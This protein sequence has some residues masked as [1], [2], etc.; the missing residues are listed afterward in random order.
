MVEDT[1]K[2]ELNIPVITVAKAEGVKIILVLGRFGWLCCCVV[3]CGVRC[4]GC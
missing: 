1:P 2:G 3:L 4:C